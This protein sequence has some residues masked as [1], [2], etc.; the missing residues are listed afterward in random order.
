MNWAEL[1]KR[2]WFLIGLIL[3]IVLAAVWP[4]AGS[5]KGPLATEYTIGYGANIVIFLLSGLALNTKVLGHAII[6]WRLIGLVQLVSFGLTP[7]IGFAVG[8][9]L[10]LA[11]FNIFLVQGIIIACSTPTTIA[12]N[13]LMTKQAK[14]NEAGALV[15]AVV[16]NVL[17]VFVSPLLIFGY[18]ETRSSQGLNFANIFGKLGL[19]VLLP[20]VVGQLVRYFFM[21]Q[22]T[23]LQQKINFSYLNSSMLL[24]LIWTVFCDTFQSG[25]FAT[26]PGYQTALIALVDFCLFLLFTCLCILRGKFFKFKEPDT[27][28]LTM[29]G[30][31]KTVALGLPLINIIFADNPAIGILTIPLLMYH[32]LQLVVGAF[33]VTWFLNQQAKSKLD[34]ELTIVELNPLSLNGD[35][36]DCI[37]LNDNGAD[38]VQVEEDLKVELK[39]GEVQGEL[40]PFQAESLIGNDVQSM[41]GKDEV[42]V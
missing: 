27:V 18:L 5:K 7:A 14:G 20:L 26:I 30:A 19:T 16:G 6:H 1:A 10:T 39:V 28:A 21:S 9:L 17:G 36:D 22:V 40:E 25:I 37:I 15:N 12:S 32:A 4:I 2:H 35:I 33:V 38:Q 42:G 41:P 23:T 3:V 29:C 31:T 24:I 13:V 11:N 34:H 8:K